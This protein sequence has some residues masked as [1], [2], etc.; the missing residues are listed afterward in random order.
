MPRKVMEFC[1]KHGSGPHADVSH[2]LWCV[3]CHPEYKV[4]QAYIAAP[5]FSEAQRDYIGLVSMVAGM[6]LL[7]LC[8]WQAAVVSY[9][10]YRYRKNMRAI[11]EWKELDRG[12]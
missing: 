1:V 9:N 11:R 2:M 3:E 7:I 8:S 4:E 6:V 10:A 5:L 12:R